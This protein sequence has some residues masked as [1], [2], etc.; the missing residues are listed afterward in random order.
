MVK[1]ETVRALALSLEEASEEPHFEKTSF[2]VRKKIFA[3]VD[4][5][6][7]KAVLKF[8]EADQSIFCAFDE[9]I[10][11]PVSG[12]WGKKGWTE[13]DLEKI[14][15][16]MFMEALTTSYCQVASKRLAEKYRPS[17]DSK[18]II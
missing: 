1:I 2:R 5:Q 9:T 7:H 6:K 13:V 3:T 4:I 15:Q 11:Y 18:N 17:N 14:T 16:E 10:I 8:S 12:A